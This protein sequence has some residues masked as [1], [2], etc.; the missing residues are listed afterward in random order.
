MRLPIRSAFGFFTVLALACGDGD[1]PTSP[2]LQK[3][4][5]AVAQTAAAVTGQDSPLADEAEGGHVLGFDTHT[6]PGDKVMK[7]WREAPGAP[8]TWVGYYLPSPCHKDASWTGKRARLD[9][10]GWGFAVVYVGQQ[11]WGTNPKV[12]SPTAALALIR[13]GRS[14]DARLLTAD[15]G[16][17]DANDAIVKTAREGFPRG[18]VVFLDLERMERIPTAMRNYYQGWVSRM[19]ADGQFRPGIYVHQHNA[20][21]IHEDVSRLYQAAGARDTARFWVAGTRGFETGK[22]P[23]D[24]GFA[25]AGVWQGVINTARTIASHALPIDINVSSWVSPSEPGRANV[26]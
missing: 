24:V 6:Y 20:Q 16:V 23:Q 8:Y 15:R 19:L 25:F 5:A 4:T 2:T 11:T 21:A 14:C 18:T 9:S 17:A 26:Q 22:A 7:A 13:R 3:V 10:L 1:E 12:L